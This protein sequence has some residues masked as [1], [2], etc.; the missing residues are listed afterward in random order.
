MIYYDYTIFL[1]IPAIILSLAAQIM[2]S[3][4]YNKYRAVRN[5]RNET[6]LRAA[7]KILDRNGLQ[8]VGVQMAHGKLSDHYDPRKRTLFLSEDV[9]EGMS[10]A[11]VSI[12]AH[13][14][15]HAI[16]HATKYIPLAIRSSIAPVASFSSQAAMILIVVGMFI[17]N[18]QYAFFGPILFD[19]GIIMYTAVLFFQ[20]VTLPVEFNASKRARECLESY[21]VVY[22][23]EMKGVKRMLAAAAMTYVAA[24]IASLLT[25]IRF[26]LIRSRR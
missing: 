10:V 3:T 15:G 21:G 24:M 7:R 8:A 25:L 14:A 12:A 16:Q 17:V 9:Y 13:E 2:V 4:A 11:A 5:R 18:T 1:L 22:G 6:G 19:I 23:D 20:T 26:L